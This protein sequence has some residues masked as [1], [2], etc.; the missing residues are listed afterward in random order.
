MVNHGSN[1]AFDTISSL[2]LRRPSAA[3]GLAVHRLVE[4]CRPLDRNSLYCNLLQC[5]HFAETCAVAVRGDTMLGFVSAYKPPASANTLFVWQVAVSPA[6]RRQGL[7]KRLL[8]EVLSRPVCQDVWFLEASVTP[9]NDASRRMFLSLAL[10]LKCPCEST[11]LF[12]SEQ[13]FGGTH[14]TETLLRIGAFKSV[15][16][17]EEGEH[18]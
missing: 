17:P 4:L 6:A 13:H 16:S 10:D 5:S 12:S 18:R 1:T 9:D 8:R 3:D 14:A 11:T 7:G 2:I 15:A